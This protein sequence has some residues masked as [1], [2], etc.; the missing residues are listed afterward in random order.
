MRVLAD[1]PATGWQTPSDFWGHPSLVGLL[2]GSDVLEQTS[3]TSRYFTL[4]VK[5]SVGTG[6]IEQTSLFEAAATGPQLA[7]RTWQD[8][9]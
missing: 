1:V 7:A 8:Q 6:E 9:L 3:V 5:V 4:H 2:P